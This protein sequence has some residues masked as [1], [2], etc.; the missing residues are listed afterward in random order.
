MLVVEDDQICAELLVYLLTRK[1]FAVFSFAD[2]LAAQNWIANRSQPVDLVLLDLMLPVVDGFQI[3]RQIH[4]KKEWAGTPVIVLSAKIQEQ[5]IVRA[6][7][8]GATDYVT[9]PFQVGEL[10]ARIMS[11]IN[12]NRR[13]G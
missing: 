6:F 1:G 10:L 4:T 8:L 13:H 2:G 11:R 5:T 3:L 12:T 7:E 9:K